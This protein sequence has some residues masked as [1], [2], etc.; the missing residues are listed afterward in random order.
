MGRILKYT[1]GILAVLIVVL[2]IAVYVFLAAYDFNGLKPQIATAVKETTGRELMIGG[3][4]DLE[5]GF[6]PSLVLTEI[7]FQNA[8][9]GSRPE[10]VKLKRFEVRI[11][12]LPLISGNIEIK[13]FV[14][15]EPDILIER[16][17]SGRSNLTFERSQK[18]E[19]GRDSNEKPTEGMT[20]PALAFNKLEI[21][22]GRLAYR[23]AGTGKTTR[24]NLN[25][26]VART[27]GMESPVEFTLDGGFDQIAF[28]L[29]GTLG[30]LA[31]LTDPKKAWP[32]KVTAKALDAVVTLEGSIKD[33]IAR[34]GMNMGFKVRIKDWTALSKFIGQ[35][36]PFKD[37]LDI[38]GRAGDVG[39]KSYKV[40][41]LRIS[42]GAHTI[43]GSVGINMK[44]KT[45]DL[46]VALSSNNLDLRPFLSKEG[47]KKPATEKHGKSAE[48]K[49]KIFPSEPLPPLDV[50]KQVDGIFK[51]RFGKVILPRVVVNDLSMDMAIKEGRLDVRPLKAVIGSGTLGGSLALTPRG[52]DA[53]IAVRLSI[54]GLELEKMLKE[55]DITELIEGSLDLDIDLKGRGASVAAIMAG[56]NGHT[57]V[58]M[59]EG[60]IN[61]KYIDLLGGDIGSSV[62]RLLNPAKEKKDYTA[63]KC[64]VSRFDIHKGLADSTA[65]VF[66]TERMSVVG[67]G[68]IDLNTEKLNLSIKPLPKEGVGGFSLS[69]GE[70]AKPFKLGGTL[71]EPS[72]GIDSTQAA[73]ALGKTI[74]GVAL[75]GPLGIAAALI[76]KGKGGNDENPCLAA[77]EAAKTGVKPSK[78][79]ETTEEKREQKKPEDALNEILPDIGKTLKGLFGR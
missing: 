67:E 43:A 5:I 62:L 38:A 20:L 63:I 77:I 23:D 51:I 17:K 14:L 41:D 19:H 69:L 4:I 49:N 18:G 79:Q 11:A 75:F 78:K 50:L 36:I 61:N 35:P 72:L 73:I 34:S 21:L 7:A 12:L 37:A 10:M 31:A 64:M 45:P 42:L 15:I 26:L 13:R 1:I 65:L 58:I 76:G 27:A 46:D 68:D 59:N 2:I 3:D 56:L 66:D 8:S 9:W 54:N 55:L 47:E 70:L 32:V 28:D 6:T 40:S 74:G 24:I 33:A 52:R 39:P 29:I 22:R 53:E 48:K 71:A 57:S 44:K 30:P 16:D 25:S 60:R